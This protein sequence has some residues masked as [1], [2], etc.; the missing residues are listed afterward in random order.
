M[1]SLVL[2]DVHGNW[3]A[4][5]AVLRAARRK[6]TR[7][8]L[9]LG[10]AVGYGASPHRVLD[11]LLGHGDGLVV[12]RG[13]HDVACASEDG[14]DMFNRFARDAVRWTRDRLD[15]RQRAYLEELPRG[16]IEIDDDLV[17]CHGSPADEDTYIFSVREARE[18][19]ETV[20]HRTILF[21][22]T[23]LPSLFVLDEETGEIEAGQIEGD[24]TGIDLADGRRY[25]INPGS[26]GQPR[27][28]DPRAAYAVHDGRRRKVWVYRTRY[29]VMGARRR[30]IRAGLPS[31]L[32]DRL[33]YGA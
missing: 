27:D 33:L 25:L 28:R 3:S 26:V 4:L 24:R 6:R 30:I 7:R 9:F 2:S 29:D 12:V 23:H 14:D 20:P 21:G 11:W 17:V 18:A 1:R 31:I 15:D 8:T 22:H 5:E 32:G 19:F 10:D 16:P 13:N